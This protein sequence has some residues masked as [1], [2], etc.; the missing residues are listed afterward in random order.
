[1]RQGSTE[2][3]DE[4][5]DKLNDPIQNL[6]LAWGEHILCSLKTMDKSGAAYKPEEA[7]TEEENSRQYYFCYGLT[8]IDMDNY[9]EIQGKHILKEETNTLIR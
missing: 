3:D 2:M 1:M 8:N 4:Y 5:L 6:I 7:T 9:L